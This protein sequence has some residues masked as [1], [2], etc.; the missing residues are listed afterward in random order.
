MK[1]SLPDSSLDQYLSR[2]AEPVARE[3]GLPSDSQFR[4]AL[5]VPFYDEPTAAFNRL[6]AAARQADVL[7][8]AVINV[9]DG[10]PDESHTRTREL[11]DHARTRADH[12]LIIDCVSPGK[13]LPQKQAVGLA[14][15]IGTDL[16]CRLWRDGYLESAWLYQTD[17]DAVLPADY[18]DHNLESYGAGALVFAHHHV[19]DAPQLARAAELYDWH[20]A[21]Y[22]TS[23]AR[24]G[25]PYAFPTLGSTIAVRADAYAAVRGYPRRNAGEDFYLLNKVQKVAG[26]RYA[27]HVTVT[28]AARRSHRVPFGTGPALADIVELL[29]RDPSGASFRSYHPRAFAL[30]GD[31]LTSL[32]RFAADA[33]HTF[34]PQVEEVL[35]ALG[36]AR[37]RALAHV[38][39][40]AEGRRQKA[41]DDWFDARRTL[42]FVHESRRFWPDQP[43]LASLATLAQDQQ[44]AIGFYN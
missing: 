3:A 16:A 39:Y 19:A 31:A 41:L 21:Y 24:V 43:L 5:I 22:H 32:R 7:L 4:A 11:L 40:P 33:D 6:Q 35:E 36:F 1:L 26:V 10:A 12:A 17:A 38:K 2:Y 29:E 14:R 44:R 9:P 28:L 20:M 15:K 42:R 18:F 23:L 25:S 37:M 27:P 8:I 30:L 13:A 34:K